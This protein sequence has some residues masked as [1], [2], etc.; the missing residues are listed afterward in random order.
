MGALFDILRYL[1]CTYGT[2]FDSIWQRP[3]TKGK[4]DL[5]HLR[6]QCLRPPTSPFLSTSVPL[7]WLNSS[8][9]AGRWLASQ[10][11]R[12]KNRL[13]QVPAVNIHPADLCALIN[14]FRTLWGCCCSLGVLRCCRCC[15]INSTCIWIAVTAWW[16]E[17]G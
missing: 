8:G 9:C 2:K 12:A 10:L 15:C 16:G 11:R 5:Q 17:R 1:R 4:V 7:T 13:L 6:A 14:S 3:L